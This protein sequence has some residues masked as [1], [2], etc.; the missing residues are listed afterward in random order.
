ME[1]DTTKLWRLTKAL[2]DE[3]NKGQKITLEED[4]QTLTDKAEANAFAQ[5]YAKESSITI[6]PILQK[7]FRKEEK[8]RTTNGMSMSRCSKISPSKN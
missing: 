1:R 7:E 8:E 4:G 5:A 2:N 6:P 3:G